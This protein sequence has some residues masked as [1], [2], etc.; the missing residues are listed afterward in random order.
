MPG[1]SRMTFTVDGAD[2]RHRAGDEA[3]LQGDRGRE[4][5]TTSPAKTWSRRELALIRVTADA[6]NRGAIIEIVD[7]F[8]ANIVDVAD[9]SLV[10]EVTGTEDKID[11]I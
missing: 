8:R 7:I 6:R 5:R 11:A 9:D 2:A 10:V 3:A 1:L 4:D